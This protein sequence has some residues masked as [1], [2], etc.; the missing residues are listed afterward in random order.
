[1]FL[2]LQFFIFNKFSETY[3]FHMCEEY[4]KTKLPLQTRYDSTYIADIYY[5]R[6]HVYVFLLGVK[7]RVFELSPV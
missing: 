5:I 3:A 7:K 4:D 1:M 2:R 6:T